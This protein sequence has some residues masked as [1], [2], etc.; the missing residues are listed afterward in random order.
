MS[1]EVELLPC[2]FC[3]GTDHF[4]FPPSCTEDAPYNPADRASP[5]VRCRTCYAEVPGKNWDHSCKTA[6]AAWNR[7]S[8][9]PS[10]GRVG[11]KELEWEPTGS[12]PFVAISLYYYIG[13]QSGDGRYWVHHRIFG[14]LREGDGTIEHH[15]TL[16][17]AKAAAQEDHERKILWQ[18]VGSSDPDVA[19]PNVEHLRPLA[20]REKSATLVYHE[21]P[22]GDTQGALPVG[23]VKETAETEHVERDALSGDTQ[24]EWRDETEAEHIAR[25]IKEGRFPQRSERQ[26]RP[27]VDDAWERI[28]SDGELDAAR[29]KLSMHELR[30]IIKHAVTAHTE[31]SATLVS[32]P[33]NGGWMPIETAPKD[34]TWIIVRTGQIQDGRWAPFSDRC[35]VVRHLG[36]TERLGID[37]GWTLFPGM[38]CGT[39]W[40]THWQP[41]PSPPALQSHNE[42]SDGK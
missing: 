5:L 20:D 3:G 9:S 42:G 29:R 21:E 30:R 6:I 19:P 36:T 18:I 7:R 4:I 24:V 37:I 1:S 14:D 41:L 28:R 22:A 35:F 23:Y 8:A 40:L 39:E 25:D 2:P 38:V 11:V 13:H 34:G 32:P 17:A 15:L 31:L 10:I 33:D 16:D 12:Y 27:A 26:K